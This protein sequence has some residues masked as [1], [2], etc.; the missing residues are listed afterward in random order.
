LTFHGEEKVPP[1]AG[2]HAHESPPVMCIPLWI[3]AAGAVGAG[4]VVEPFTHWFSGFLRLHWIDFTFAPEA[5]DHAAPAEGLN[6][7]LMLISTLAALLGIAL[8]WGLYLARPGLATRLAIRFRG[9][10]QLSL[11]RF[12]I[13]ELY[14]FFVVQ[15][16][17]GLAKFCRIVDLYVVDSIV[18]LV[19]NLPALFGQ[20]FRPLQNG[21]VQF[22][23]LAMLLGLT[24]FL[25]ALVRALAG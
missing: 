6:Y 18:D 3:L 8:A 22:Y 21:L 4:I 7:G 10:Y 19:G 1:E 24:V 5:R 14:D 12:H 11:N 9:L 20:L 2:G 23:A 15:P 16:L 25:I 17:I 13:D